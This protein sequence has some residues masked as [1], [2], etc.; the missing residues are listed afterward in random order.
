MKF[1]RWVL[2]IFFAAFCV[3][4]ALY[5]RHE[6]TIVWNPVDYQDLSV[7]VYAFGLGLLLVGF[8][9]GVLVSWF[10]GWAK[11]REVKRQ[12]KVISGLEKQIELSNENVSGS[13]DGAPSRFL[14]I[15]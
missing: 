9:W 5:N 11:R 4:F 6:T 1:I 10:G 14:Q 3:L 8:F 13:T 12:A 15:R 2:S 7:P